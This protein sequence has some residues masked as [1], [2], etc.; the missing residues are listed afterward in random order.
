MVVVVARNASL[1]RGASAFSLTV[2]VFS[3]LPSVASVGAA[4]GVGVAAGAVAGVVC[5]HV[6]IDT[7]NIKAA[8]GNSA[9]PW[10]AEAAGMVCNDFDRAMRMLL[11]F[12]RCDVCNK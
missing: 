7:D 10:G 5:A 4:A 3:V 6:F 8:T 2:T 11:A 1:P 9:T 12:W